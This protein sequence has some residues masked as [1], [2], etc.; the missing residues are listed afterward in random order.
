MLEADAPGILVNDDILDPVD[1]V[2]RRKKLW[3]S[4]SC[5]LLPMQLDMT[6]NL[7]HDNP[8]TQPR[9]RLIAIVILN[10]NLQGWVVDVVH[11]YRDFAR[12]TEV[13][14]PGDEFL[15]EQARRVIDVVKV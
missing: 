9:R 6:V 4:I 11:G 8:T 5:T 1:Q 10:F 3:K 2:T 12:R 13:G 7:I 15:V 14:R